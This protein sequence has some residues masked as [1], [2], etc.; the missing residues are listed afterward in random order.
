M[1]LHELCCLCYCGTWG[2]TSLVEQSGATC[3]RVRLRDAACFAWL[4]RGQVSRHISARSLCAIVCCEWCQLSRPRR[5]I[6]LQT[7]RPSPCAS[8]T[9]ASATVV[10]PQEST[11]L[12]F[13]CCSVCARRLPSCCRK[14]VGC[15]G[16]GHRPLCAG[17]AE[18]VVWGQRG[19]QQR[20]RQCTEQQ[21]SSQQQQWQE[22]A[23]GR[24]QAA[25]WYRCSSSL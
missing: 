11:P 4:A 22:K 5:G 13:G 19:R 15:H 17:S 20:R 21:A 10:R 23:R 9:A 25:G 6:C 7:S 24:Q 8:R 3:W 16:Q 14:P 18:A 2:F 1:R 12:S